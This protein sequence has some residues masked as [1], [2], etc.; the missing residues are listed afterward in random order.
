MP[1]SEPAP[2]PHGADERKRRAGATP[3]GQHVAPADPRVANPEAESEW[4]MSLAALGE[5]LF[6]IVG[7]TVPRR[8]MEVGAW[9]GELT[10]K[11]IEWAERSDATVIG[12]EPWPTDELRQEA[13][14]N[15]HFELVEKHSHDVL[16]TLDPCDL[17]ILDSDH[18][19]YVVHGELERIWRRLDG[20]ETPLLALV[21]DVGW[22]WGRRD[23]YGDPRL[24]PAEHRHPYSK[25]PIDIDHP[26]VAPSGFTLDGTGVVALHEGGPRNGT[27]TA[28]EDFVS[29][30]PELTMAVFPLHYG[31]AV[32]WDRGAPWAADLEALLAP[33][34]DHPVL[35]RV[36]RNRMRLMLRTIKAMEDLEAVRGSWLMRATKPARRVWYRIGAKRS[37]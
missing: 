14:R 25:A 21:H 19:Y 1:G 15:D 24:I 22:P 4:G 10:F 3:A 37:S 7:V 33:Y 36:E 34:A 18:N 27:R 2:D 5:L 16:Q 28:I 20:T 23:G 13:E 35:A 12:V 17:Y 8:L 32:V 26:G 11:L 6:E 9:K 31:L 30:R 29:E